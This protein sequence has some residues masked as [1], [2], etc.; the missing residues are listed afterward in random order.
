MK[1]SSNNVSKATKINQRKVEQ[2]KQQKL[3]KRLMWIT[4]AITVVIIALVLMPSPKEKPIEIAYDSLPRLGEADAPVKL[5]VLSDYKCP[6]CQFYDQQMKPQLIKDYVE[7]GI[8]S[9]YHMNYPFIGPDS[10][11]AALAAQSVFHESNESF[12]KYHDRLYQNQG[13]ETQ[14]WATPEFL[15]ELSQGDEPLIDASK[16]KQEIDDKTYRNE[17]DEQYDFAKKNKATGT[18]TFY[19]NGVKYDIQLNY[20]ALKEV[21]EQARNGEK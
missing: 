2:E 8:V 16:L 15:V 5:V 19:I 3:I 6:A 12:W 20:N 13:E 18:P 14:Q 1:K 4:A 9:I 21:I 10:Y 17:V 11:T 7:Q